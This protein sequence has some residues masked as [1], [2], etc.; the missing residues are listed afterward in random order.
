MKDGTNVNAHHGRVSLKESRVQRLRQ[1]HT[2]KESRE[3]NGSDVEDGAN[4]DNTSTHHDANPSTMQTAQNEYGATNALPTFIRP[5]LLPY[6]NL[7]DLAEM[8]Q[9]VFRFVEN[10]PLLAMMGSSNSSSSTENDTTWSDCSRPGSIIAASPQQ[11]IDWQAGD[12]LDKSMLLTSLLIGAGY[13]AYVVLGMA[14]SWLC[15]G[16]TGLLEVPANW[17][18]DDNYGD[19]QHGWRGMPL[20]E[21]DLLAPESDCNNLGLHAWVLVRPGRRGQNDEN[22]AAVFADPMVG[23]IFSAESATD[24]QE[25]SSPYA[26]IASIFSNTNQWTN[27]SSDS[28]TCMPLRVELDDGN[29]WQTIYSESSPV[30]PPWANKINICQSHV[31][32]RYPR[33]GRRVELY[34]KAKLELFAGP[35]DE[36]RKLTRYRDE[37]R[38]EEVECLELH[39]EERTD[40]LKQRRMLPLENKMTESYSVFHPLGLKQWSETFGVES[41]ISFH[42][43]IRLDGLVCRREVF[44]K[45]IEETFEDRPD[46]LIKRSIR[47]KSVAEEEYLQKSTAFLTKSDG[48]EVTVTEI[49]EQYGNAIDIKANLAEGSTVVASRTFHLIGGWIDVTRMHNDGVDITTSTDR[50]LT[51]NAG[52]ESSIEVSRAEREALNSIRAINTD[53]LHLCRLR[54]KEEKDNKPYTANANNCG[55]NKQEEQKNNEEC[56]VAKNTDYL[57]PFLVGVR[58][59]EQLSSEEAAQ[60]KEACLDALSERLLQRAQMMQSRL[61]K[62]RRLLSETS[63]GRGNDDMGEESMDSMAL[64]RIR[65]WEERLENHEAASLKRYY[66]LQAR[67][68]ADP[69]LQAHA[70]M[71]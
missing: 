6:P 19:A 47:V 36:T 12:S 58:N 17:E 14:P 66:V 43:R 5:T 34:D 40:H 30:P 57:S 69:R 22:D 39:S 29:V 48:T 27:V 10:E 62:E 9:F 67:L 45:L 23:R 64:D 71:K 53:M 59:I 16:D 60:I 26:S 54:Y 11:T 8:L 41:T 50:L 37:E 3:E 63:K 7:Y 70:E 20:S 4:N 68:D 33:H 44:G 28:D 25:P 2:R 55:Y 24:E 35:D 15:N 13:D 31:E 42:S 61:D 18:G 49:E 51:K 65:I 32:L 21:A 46:G 1:Q 56:D 38:M 52:D